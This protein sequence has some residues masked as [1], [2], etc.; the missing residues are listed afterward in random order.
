MV[1]HGTGIRI[2]KIGHCSFSRDDS[3][4]FTYTGSQCM[5]IAFVSLTKH[6][7]HSI[8]SRSRDD[9]DCVLTLGDKVYS[10]S[11]DT[12]KIKD[13][14]Q[15]LSTIE[16]PDKVDASDH[17]LKCT[18]A[19]MVTGFVHLMEHHDIAAEAHHTLRNGQKMIFASYR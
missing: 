16:L 19:Y 15:H 4:C 18:S 2:L 6:T 12:H 17:K 5:A 10:N 13:D 1:C 3:S 9:L 7:L 8:L 14:Q 11:C